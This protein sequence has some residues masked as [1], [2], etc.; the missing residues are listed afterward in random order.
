MKKLG[1]YVIGTNAYIVLAIRF[2]K[3]F[4]KY[5][6]G[7]FYLQF[8]IFSDSDPSECLPDYINYKYFETKHNSWLEGTNSKFHNILDNKDNIDVDYLYYFDAD[9]NINKEFGDWF[10]GGNI[11][12]GE[13]FG[14][15]T[16]MAF[17]PDNPDVYKKPFDR[18]PISSCCL[19]GS[20]EHLTYC[21]G[22]FFG[23]RY[24]KVL[25]MLSELNELMEINKSKNY[26]PAVNDESYL[27]YYFNTRDVTIIPSSKFE[28][29]ISCKGGIDNTRDVNLNIDDLKS[30]MARCK[31]HIFDLA[32]GRLILQSSEF[33][34]ESNTTQ[35]SAL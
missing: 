16:Y 27:N 33:L 9:T 21:Y 10:I 8:F 26:E 30:E 7:N 2:I 17:D 23:G 1:I 18:N 12:A 32:N 22:A 4:Y 25:N 35:C 24:E 6:K 13:H 5:Y 29:L 31:N 3:K 34:V 11:V 15:S 14:N 28:F 20:E 19:G